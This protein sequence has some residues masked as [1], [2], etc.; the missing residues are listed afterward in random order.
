MNSYST[1]RLGCR[2]R[3]SGAVI[4]LYNPNYLKDGIIS[5]S[6]RGL[7]LTPDEKTIITYE[8]NIKIWD[9]ATGKLLRTLKGH[10]G[11]VYSVAISNDGSTVVSGSGDGTVK[12]WDLATGKLL[13]TLS[14]HSSY[15]YSVAI[16]N[17]GSTLVSGSNDTDIR[18]WRN[19]IPVR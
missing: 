18:V 7:V 12:I 6:G 19:A 17:D 15:V 9:L 3:S 8:N 13:R 11:S 2:S 14:G 1:C 5:G 10:S 16:S 4:Y